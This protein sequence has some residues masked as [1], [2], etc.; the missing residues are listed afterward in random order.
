MTASFISARFLS[1][2]HRRCASA[3]SL[4]RG[5]YWRACSRSKPMPGRARWSR[6]CLGEFCRKHFNAHVPVLTR[7]LRAKL[8]TLMGALNEQFGTAAEF[9]DPKG[10]IFLW[11]KLPGQVDTQRLFAP[12]LAAGV[13]INP[14]AEWSTDKSYGRS[15][16]RLCFANPSPEAIRAGIAALAEVCRHEFGVPAR[17]ANVER[18]AQG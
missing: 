15:R 11:V 1:R 14:G 12:A 4:R 6:W 5:L 2:S 3:T 7:A 18:R 8:E 9:E 17:I 13:A 16:T 10:G